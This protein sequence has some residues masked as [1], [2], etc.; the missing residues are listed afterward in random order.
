[1]V[2]MTERHTDPVNCLPQVTCHEEQTAWLYSQRV[3]TATSGLTL[4]RAPG[5]GVTGRARVLPQLPLGPLKLASPLST[6]P[7]S[8]PSLQG[9]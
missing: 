7:S 2:P 8:V 3:L 1:M 5:A 9:F 6:T 4:R